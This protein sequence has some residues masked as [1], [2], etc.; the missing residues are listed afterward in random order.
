MT[1]PTTEAL[2]R[3]PLALLLGRFPPEEVILARVLADHYQHVA[4]TARSG[5]VDTADAELRTLGRDVPVP[6]AP[7]LRRVVDLAAL[8][9][10]ALVR[11]GEGRFAAARELLLRALDVGAEL[12]SR[13]GHYYLTGKR[14]HF[15]ANLVRVATAEGRHEEATALL[16]D[17]GAVSGGERERWPFTGAVTLDVPL[18]DDVR[19]FI[20]AQLRR[21]A[22]RLEGAIR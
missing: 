7:E 5:R 4:T 9:A 21:E 15:A 16:A 2:R 20:H 1:D 13:Y 11:F 10:A 18:P 19:A 8:P 6:D 17:L 12:A 22:D 14:L 3:R